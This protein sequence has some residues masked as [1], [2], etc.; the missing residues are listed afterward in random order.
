MEFKGISP[1]SGTSS[2]PGDELC[3]RGKARWN[4]RSGKQNSELL[5][6]GIDESASLYH[7]G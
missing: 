6:P 1:L 2:V 5:Y 4:L 7:A 3:P